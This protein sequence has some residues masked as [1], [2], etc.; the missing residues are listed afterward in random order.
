MVF[1]FWLH[2]NAFFKELSMTYWRN[3]T[4]VIYIFSLFLALGEEDNIKK[5]GFVFIFCLF[6]LYTYRFKYKKKLF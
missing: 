5:K 1:I 3:L 6:H 4:P 2:F